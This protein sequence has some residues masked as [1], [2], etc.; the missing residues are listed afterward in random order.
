MLLLAIESSI[1]LHWPST[2]L[3]LASF[4]YFLIFLFITRYSVFP[5]VVVFVLFQS[6]SG[7]AQVQ[8]VV[9]D[10]GFGLWTAE[11]YDVCRCFSNC[12]VE[13]VGDG[14]NVFLQEEQRAESSP[15]VCLE[16]VGYIRVFELVETKL[17]PGVRCLLGV[18]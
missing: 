18:L 10:P 1:S 17:K 3:C 14:F 2:H 13:V 15:N 9:C 7:V 11:A 5:V 8:D 12:C 16:Q 4:I 6:P